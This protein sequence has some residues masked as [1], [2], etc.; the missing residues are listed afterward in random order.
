MAANQRQQ[1]QEKATY[2]TLIGIFLGIFAAF[3][4]REQDRHRGLELSPMDLTLLG[5]STYRIGRL[6]A[7]DQVTRPLREPLTETQPDQ[8]GT[9][10]TVVAQGSGVQKALGELV[11]CPTCV[12]TWAAAFLVYAL[13][14]APKPTRLFL[15]F[16]GATGLA[17][18]LDSANEALNWTGSAERKQAA[19]E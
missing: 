18:L 1:T 13:R 19:P 5:L 3:S 15:A 6:A 16:M 11:A 4:K 17:E 10:E 2:L 7:F 9:S 12:G 14:L 8:Y